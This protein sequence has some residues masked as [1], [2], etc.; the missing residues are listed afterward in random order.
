V[1]LSYYHQLYCRFLAAWVILSATFGQIPAAGSGV[2]D[3]NSSS[4]NGL[5]SPKDG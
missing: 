3:P 5:M 2:Y 4:T 1:W